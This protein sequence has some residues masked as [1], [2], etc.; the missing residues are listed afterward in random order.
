[1]PIMLQVRIL[2]GKHQHL[3]LLHPIAHAV[4][5]DGLLRHGPRSRGRL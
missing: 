1:L 3:L 5:H 4:P 2:P